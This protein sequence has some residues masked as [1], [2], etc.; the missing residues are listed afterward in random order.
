MAMTLISEAF[1]PGETIPDRYTCEGDDVS[2]PLKWREVPPEAESLVLI[3]DDPDAPGGTWS[4]WVLY[5]L[6][7]GKSSL[8]E[9]ISPDPE[10]PDGGVHG[11]NG[12]GHLGYGGPCPPRGE[13]HHYYFRLYALNEKLDLPPG[14]TRSQV[15]DRVEGHTLAKTELMGQ[16]QR[17]LLV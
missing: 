16:Y 10:L 7:S 2:P 5:D 8:D 3:C 12:F 13:M 14:A 4:H 9:G 6:P 1:E 17:A 11:R 15:L